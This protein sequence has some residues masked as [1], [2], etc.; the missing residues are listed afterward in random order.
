MLQLDLAV[1]RAEGT[2]E[3]A[4]LAR[5]LDAK[6]IVRQVMGLFCEAIAAADAS[7]ATVR[8]G[9]ATVL[10][11]RMVHAWASSQLGHGDTAKDSIEQV[12]DVSART[13]E[14]RLE[15]YALLA[16]AE[17]ARFAA[18][19]QVA[20]TRIARCVGLANA[21]EF[22]WLEAFALVIQGELSLAMDAHDDAEPLLLGGLRLATTIGDRCGRA[23]A[24]WALGELNALHG[25][26]DAALARMTEAVAY[27]EEVGLRIAV[28]HRRRLEQMTWATAHGRPEA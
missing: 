14:P 13:G 23:R 5:A 3:D 1:R 28:E 27:E 8:A 4:L 7:L 24:K 9:M 11:A 6:A 10:I 21:M 19:P 15:A 20:I 2:T 16:G 17:V 22:R 18:E 25:Q 12:L 26:D